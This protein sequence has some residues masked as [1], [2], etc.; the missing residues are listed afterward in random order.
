MRRAFALASLGLLAAC[1]TSST[2]RVHPEWQ[3]RL[4]TARAAVVCPP[5][6][7]VLRPDEEADQEAGQE[8]GQEEY[9]AEELREFQEA[10]MVTAIEELHSGGYSAAAAPCDH[11]SAETVQAD[12]RNALG[13]LYED[14]H[15]TEPPEGEHRTCQVTLAP[16]FREVWRP[17][18]TGSW[19]CASRSSG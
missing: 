5:E 9:E 1:A 11:P 2:A 14:N 7:T 6:V 16:S 12:Y 18:W 15:A 3:Q 19:P 4:R 17:A 13:D 8:A 10:L